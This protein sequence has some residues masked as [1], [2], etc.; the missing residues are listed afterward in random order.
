MKAMSSVH[1]RTLL[2]GKV[3]VRGHSGVREGPSRDLETHE[4][5]C[6]EAIVRRARGPTHQHL[7]V[8]RVNERLTAGDRLRDC[9]GAR[10][11]VCSVLHRR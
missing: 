10:G 7:K 8:R 5:G 3:K 4:A 9:W 11:G 6:V 2:Q 1:A